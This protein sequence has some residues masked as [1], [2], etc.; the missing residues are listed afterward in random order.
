M[1]LI[2]GVEYIN[3]G[4]YIEKSTQNNSDLKYG[5]ELILG[6]NNEGVFQKPKTDPYSVDLKPYKV[7]N[8]G[9]FVYNPSRLDLGSIAYR[10]DGLCIVSHLYMVVYLNEKGKKRIDPYYLYMYFRRQEFY[11]EVR[12]RN[13][14]SQRPEFNFN[15]LSE[16]VIP[17]PSLEVQK[18]YVAIY[19]AMVKNQEDYENGL[20]D[21]KKSV[22]IEIEKIK[23]TAPRRSVSELLTE[24]DT[25]NVNGEIQEVKGLN[26][27][28]VFM[29]SVADTTNANLNNYKVVCKGQFAY[30][31]MQTG[32]DKCIRIALYDKAD[33]IIISPAYSVLETK[34]EEAVS[35]Y[36]MLWFMRPETDRYGWF[37]SD[38]SIRANLDLDRFYEMKIP[39]PDKQ[40]Q[41]AISEIYNAFVIR[42]D[43]NERLKA[44]IKDLCPILIKGSIEEARK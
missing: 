44:Q 23:R 36:I 15:D 31:S 39:V 38:S 30:S 40:T 24:V 42:R 33:P 43:I 12:F 8:N 25:R 41:L 14:G 13:W 10:T 17:M 16:L 27:N 32:R 6:V 7:V 2:K 11:R 21:L 20:D 37:A 18:K 4:E 26:I 34:N 9:A 28:K 5:P 19:Q 35:E 1:G 3:L 22:F 29:D